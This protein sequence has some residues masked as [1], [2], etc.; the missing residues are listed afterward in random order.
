MKN[1]PGLR[2]LGQKTAHALAYV[3]IGAGLMLLIGYQKAS[4]E[5]LLKVDGIEIRIDTCSH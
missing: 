4:L 5:I 1:L 2:R 3:S